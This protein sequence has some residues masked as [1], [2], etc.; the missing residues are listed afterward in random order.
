MIGYAGVSVLMTEDTFFSKLYLD[1]TWGFLCKTITVGPST[2]KQC[3]PS[4]GQVW[5]EAENVSTDSASSN[6]R[7]DLP[8]Q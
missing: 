2:T 5:R 1:T 8:K 4:H 3:G 6:N 7:L